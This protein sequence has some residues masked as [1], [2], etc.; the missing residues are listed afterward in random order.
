VLLNPVTKHRSSNIVGLLGRKG[1]PIRQGHKSTVAKRTT[2]GDI[3]KIGTTYVIIQGNYEGTIVFGKSANTSK[4]EDTTA[5]KTADPRY[6][7]PRW[8]PSE[9]TRSQKQKIAALESKREQ[10]KRSRKI[11]NDTHPHT[12]H[13]KKGG[14]QRLS[15]QIKRSQKQKTRQQLHNSLQV[16]RTVQ[17]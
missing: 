16:W 17:L 6:S 1:R 13:R 9:L 11:F 8:C 10:G 7:M 5:S 2:K 3:I 12:H 15:K 4:E 14:G